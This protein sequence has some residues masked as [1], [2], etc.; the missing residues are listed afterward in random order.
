MITRDM[1]DP[2]RPAWN[3]FTSPTGDAFGCSGRRSLVSVTCTMT[4]FGLLS[5][6]T[7]NLVAFGRPMT[8]R[9]R[10]W[11][12]SRVPPGGADAVG[13]DDTPNRF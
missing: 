13:S 9:V 1:S 6:N 12:P 8:K 4:R 11:L 5:E 3:D 7:S 10:C 2:A